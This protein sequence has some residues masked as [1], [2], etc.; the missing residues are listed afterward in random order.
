MTVIEW[1][2]L[3]GV[4]ICLLVCILYWFR[5]TIKIRNVRHEEI[6]WFISQTTGNKEIQSDYVQ[7][8]QNEAGITAV[9]A[10][11]IGKENTGKVAAQIAVDTALDAFESYRTLHNPEYLFQTA[12]LEAHRRIQQTI[13]ERRGGASMAVLF[14]N[15]TH[16]YYAL[17]G[18]IRIALLRNEELIPLSEGQTLDVLAR[19]AYQEGCLSRDKTIWSQTETQIWNYLGKDG[20]HE[21]E[22]CKPPISLQPGDLIVMLSQGIY[23]ELSWVDIEEI[24]L[25]EVTLKEKAGSIIEG[26]EKKEA[27]DKEN[28]SV[29]LLATEVHHEKSQF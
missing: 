27:Q 23:E 20:F 14:V 2:L 12:F 25:K 5:L 24:L 4:S 17:A 15:Q 19:K 3:A 28:G 6:G 22:I 18:N 16:L 8:F 11:G 13:G 9:M 21:I 29:L 10:D 1:F 26:T 7:V